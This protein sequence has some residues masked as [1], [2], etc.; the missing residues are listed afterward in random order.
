M[1]ENGYTDREIAFC[2]NYI[3]N[4][5]NATQAAIKAGYSEKTAGVIA[6]ENLKKPKI[7]QYVKKRIKELLSETEML[8]LEWL[9][10][11]KSIAT[12]D[13]RDVVEWDD[14]RVTL[15][16]SDEIPDDAAIALN[17]VSQTDTMHGSTIRIKANDKNKALE[18][19]GKY[20]AILNDNAP[21]AEE[22]NSVAYKTAKERK[23]RILELMRKRDN[24]DI[25]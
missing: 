2:E 23:E 12:F 16:S 5:F 4:N 6:C 20:L 18:L 15:K 17:E 13:L 11:V 22:Q 24:A 10:H 21:T 3:S 1:T 9:R 19:L 7:R 14:G 8:T 25:D